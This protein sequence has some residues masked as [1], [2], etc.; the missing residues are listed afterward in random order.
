MKFKIISVIVSALTLLLYSYIFT[1]PHTYCAHASCT[2]S[3]MSQNAILIIQGP[4]LLFHFLF[5]TILNPFSAIGILLLVFILVRFFFIKFRI[6]YLALIL[7]WETIGF[8]ILALLSI[9]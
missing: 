8:L 5:L 9:K 2:L 7:A 6:L 1:L 4:L 3:I